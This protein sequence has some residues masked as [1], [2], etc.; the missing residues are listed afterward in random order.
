MLFLKKSCLALSTSS[1]AWCISSVTRSRFVEGSSCISCDGASGNFLIQKPC[2]PITTGPFHCKLSL[3][4]WQIMSCWSYS[5]LFSHS[6]DR[7]RAG[8]RN[9]NS[10]NQRH[11]GSSILMLALI[12]IFCLFIQPPST[13]HITLAYLSHSMAYI[14]WHALLNNFTFDS[15]SVFSFQSVK[16]LQHKPLWDLGQNCVLLPRIYRTFSWSSENISWYSH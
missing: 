15:V 5:W 9:G 4:L 3:L 6:H 1:H 8:N 12:W 13:S 14:L 11:V 2:Y 16:Q 7:E 10:G